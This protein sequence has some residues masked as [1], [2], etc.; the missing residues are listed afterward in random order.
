MILLCQQ[1]VILTLITP[2]VP[3]VPTNVVATR[4]CSQEFVEVTWQVSRGAKNYTASAKDR[5]GNRLECVSNQ[6]SCR[7]ERIMCSQ[8]YNISVIAV[9]DTCTSMRSTVVVLPTGTNHQQ[10][11]VC[12][13]NDVM[14]LTYSLSILCRTMR[15]HQSHRRSE[16]QQQL[17][18]VNLEQQH[19][20]SVLQGQGG[21]QRRT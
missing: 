18:Q 9:G 5:D 6:T 8:V 20:R 3:C 17:C 12:I 10:V 15:P 19:Q 21:E 4:N 2:P 13:S 14:I 1:F 16:L 7:I 11:C